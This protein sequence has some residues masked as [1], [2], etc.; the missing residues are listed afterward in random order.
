MAIRALDRGGEGAE[1]FA[2]GGSDS[3]SILGVE[4]IDQVV[5]RERIRIV[6]VGGI[7]SANACAAVERGIPRVALGFEAETCGFFG[8]ILYRA[9][10][11]KRVTAGG[12]S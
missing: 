11:D 12:A 6:T 1:E 9:L 5:L 8:S 10:L 7:N 3:T 4:E 2:D